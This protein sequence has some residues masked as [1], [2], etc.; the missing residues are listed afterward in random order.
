MSHQKTDQDNNHLWKIWINNS[1]LGQSQSSQNLRFWYSRES[2]RS[3][4][5]AS[6][7]VAAHTPLAGFVSF[8]TQSPQHTL[9]SLL[10]SFLVTFLCTWDCFRTLC[11]PFSSFLSPVLWLVNS[12]SLDLFILST[13]KS[14]LG[15]LETSSCCAGNSLGLGKIG[16]LRTW[17]FFPFLRWH[18]PVLPLSS[19]KNSLINII[20]KI[21]FLG[22]SEGSWERRKH[23]KNTL[24]GK[25]LNENKKNT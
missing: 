4:S 2:I 12:R 23:D 11:R 9:S 6:I 7:R 1:I 17:T 18:S 21:V 25:F 19:F 16:Q 13:Q 15:F 10:S 8:I 3:P 5:F 22:E 20:L 14:L 24:F